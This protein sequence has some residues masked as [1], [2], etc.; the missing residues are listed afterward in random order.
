MGDR[1]FLLTGLCLDTEVF[2]C[3]FVGVAF[4]LNVVA[5]AVRV[6]NSAGEY[7]RTSIFG[8]PSSSRQGRR[9]FSAGFPAIGFIS[10]R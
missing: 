7:H 10:A 8:P 3:F 9:N 1:N 5:I 6:G 4:G 2:S